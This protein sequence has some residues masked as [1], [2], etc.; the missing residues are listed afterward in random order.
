MGLTNETKAILKGI[1]K[2]RRILLAR[3][4]ATQNLTPISVRFYEEDL[5]Y[6]GI[7]A[8]LAMMPRSTFIRDAALKNAAVV[9]LD[10]AE[11]KPEDS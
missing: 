6:I 11:M 9:I 7:A 4:K 1:Q 2:R 8:A 10:Y 3:A 5:S